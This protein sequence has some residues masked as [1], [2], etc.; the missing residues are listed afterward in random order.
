MVA[1]NYGRCSR[2]RPDST[3]RGRSKTL[4]TTER[5]RVMKPIMLATDGSPSAEDAT[6]EAI[7]LA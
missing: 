3:P 4:F 7:T 5:S 1:E 6:L 2:A